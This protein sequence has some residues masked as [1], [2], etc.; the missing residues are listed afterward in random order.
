MK[1]TMP[2]Y[3]MTLLLMTGCGHVITTYSK[4]VGLELAWSAD[5]IAPAVRMG[6]YENVDVAQKENTQVRYTS[7]TGLGFDM[8]GIGKIIS[9]FDGKQNKSDVG[10][11][12]VLE[13]KSGPMI[14]GYVA[15]VLQSPNIR[16]EHVEIARSL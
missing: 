14:T 12:T 9:L 2:L 8:F 13:V 6:T 1:T 10:I 16:Q 7:N 15:D 11:G 3:L 4:G 5:T